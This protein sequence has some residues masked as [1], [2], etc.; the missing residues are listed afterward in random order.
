MQTLPAILAHGASR[1]PASPAVTDGETSRNWTEF[2]AHVTGLAA[3]LHAEGVG[4]GVRVALWLPNSAD[5]LALI[6]ACA[7]LGAL[8][9]H[10]NTRFRAAEVAS[11]LNRSGA[12]VLVTEWGFAP[13]DFPTLL[14]G[15]AATDRPLLRLVLGRHLPDGVTH[16]ANLPAQRLAP[17]AGDVPDA[18][19][20]ESHCLT[21]TTSGT[22]SGPKLVLHAQRSIALH[23]ADVARGLG[24]DAPASA[25][26]S[27]VPLC[28]TFGNAAAMGAI[29]AGA[30]VVC[31]DRFDGAAA[32]ALIR[33]HAITHS[34]GGDDMMARIAEAA[35]ETPFTTLRFFGFA[36]FHSAAA[37]SAAAGQKAGMHP[38]GVYGSS[39]VQALFSVSHGANTLLGGGIPN[40][41]AAEISIRDPETGEALP[42]GHSGEICFRAPS[43]FLRY[44]GN[45]AATAKSRTPDGFFRSGDLGRKDGD[46]FVYEARLGDTLRLGGFLVNP[47]EIEGFLMTLPGVQGAQVVAARPPDAQ[48]AVPV[49]FVIG[50]GL[51]E[52]DLL[53][54]C[55]A[56][57]ARF[58]VPVRIAVVDAFPTTDSPNG[59]K[60]QR[61]RLREQADAL[62]RSHAA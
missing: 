6:F 46:A 1:N 12:A 16:I 47:E 40:C 23:A 24:L 54:A 8:V 42:D 35:G 30:H 29:A 2:T 56:S 20:P 31:M 7:R 59:V 60:I 48:D 53:A 36:A 45:D 32:T 50:N 39:E 22:T 49:G 14:A 5:Y 3:Q 43:L 9:I 27:V 4:P 61:V 11:L 19:T 51:N 28:G 13:V 34:V 18:S 52:Q 21:Y 15:I 58:K 26:L 62:L 44:L 33:R 17:I 25:L 38:H 55:R 37:L 41:P 57:I 10:I